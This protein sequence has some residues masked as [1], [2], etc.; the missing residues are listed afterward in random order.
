MLK[1]GSLELSLVTWKF[2]VNA[3]WHGENYDRFCQ[4][5]E[6]WEMKRLCR[7]EKNVPGNKRLLTCGKRG[8]GR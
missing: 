6:G 4:R 5:R 7:V 1:W 3:G 2:L 8:H